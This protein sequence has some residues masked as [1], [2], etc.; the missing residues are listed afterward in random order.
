M[1]MEKDIPTIKI[2]MDKK[3]IRCHK[4]GATEGGLCMGC[5]SKGI[6]KGEYDHIL[7][8][9]ATME[10]YEQ[11]QEVKQFA[12][13]IIPQN[14][15]HLAGANIA[16][17]MKMAER[18]KKGNIKVSEMRRAGKHKKIASACVVPAKYFT[19]CGFHFLIVVKE[20]SWVFLSEQQ[21]LA[22]LD[23]ELSHCLRDADGFYCGDH[24]IEEFAGIIERHGAWKADVRRFI[25]AIQKVLPFEP[26]P[27]GAIQQPS[28]AVN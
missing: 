10:D 19:L 21:K 13:K 23:H 5:I 25:D 14:H 9:G 8:K 15:I 27:E 24:D 28:T 4:G 6:K 26:K 2:Y 16:Y 22:L 18:D 3:C 7:R 11:S 12:K 20:E 1:I 17:V